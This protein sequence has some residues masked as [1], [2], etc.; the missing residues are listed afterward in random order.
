MEDV[1][2]SEVKEELNANAARREELK[3]KA[4][5]EPESRS[6]ATEALR[7]LVEPSCSRQTTPVRRFRSS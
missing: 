2:A 5:N 3:T 7:G 6:E 1:P 4:L